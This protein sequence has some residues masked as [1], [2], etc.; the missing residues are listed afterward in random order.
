MKTNN[1]IRIPMSVD[2]VSRSW[3][4]MLRP[5]H[6]LSGK[7]L[8]MATL[9]LDKMLAL[10]K[11]GRAAPDD[12]FISPKSKAELKSRLGITDAYMRVIFTR[13]RKAGF[14]RPDGTVNK[15][16]IPDIDGSDHFRFLIDF[17]IDERRG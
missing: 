9:I 3:L 13:L 12:M 11:A 4:I 1:I 7:S 5:M 2:E 6:K 10:R 14:I 8:D 15:R 17:V 16:F